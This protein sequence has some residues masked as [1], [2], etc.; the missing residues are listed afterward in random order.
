MKL[1]ASLGV[2]LHGNNCSD[3]S[4]LKFVDLD[5]ATTGYEDKYPAHPFSYI[6]ITP[7]RDDVRTIVSAERIDI[8]NSKSSLIFTSSTGGFILSPQYL[9]TEDPISFKHKWLIDPFAFLAKSL[10]LPLF[11]VPDPTTLNGRRVA[12]SHVDAD[13]FSGQSQLDPKKL[14]A[15]V[16]LEQVFSQ[17][18]F[19]IAVSVIQ[20]EVDPAVHG[21]DRLMAVARKIMA[22]PNVEP[23]SHTFSHPFF[24]DPESADKDNYDER[25]AF[26]IPGYTFDAVKEIV[27][28]TDFVTNTLAPPGKPF[29]LLFWSGACDPLAAHQRI[30]TEHGLLAINGGDTVWD[31]NLDSLFNV[32]PLHHPLGGGQQQIYIGQANDNIL[33]NL[34]QGP[35]NGYRNV[36]RTMERT[37]SPRRLKPI[38]AYFHFFSGEK[39]A[40][41]N[42]IKEVYAWIADQPVA[43]VRVSRYIQSMMDWLGER[44]YRLGPDLYA[45]EGYGDCLTLRLPEDGPFPDLARCQNVLGYDREPQG[46]YVHLAP[47]AHRAVVALTRTLPAAPDKPFLQSANG[48][49][50]AMRVA[51]GAV[52]LETRFFIGNGTLTL[53]GFPPGASVAVSGSAVGGTP[54]TQRVEK[55]GLVALKG[56]ASG[57]LEV[58]RP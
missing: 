32:F 11:P 41:V 28:S 20:A 54:R 12:F 3:R 13:G 57:T 19:P 2:Q 9:R 58:T 43:P 38:D 56:L 21:S 51:P 55:D 34:W 50:S 47:G 29:R 23:A 30:A 46:I 40:G 31:P 26:D 37:G 39:L 4:L 18:D 22:L 42:A 53:A 16:M 14:C 27:G 45:V 52:R 6:K 49:V 25:F 7:V 24:W 10:D 8:P 33:T 48:L 36:I 15:D 1:Y 17:T 44:V 35:F 5:E